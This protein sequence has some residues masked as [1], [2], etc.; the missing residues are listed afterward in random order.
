MADAVSAQ[1]WYAAHIKPLLFRKPCKPVHAFHPFGLELYQD[2]IDK[3]LLYL[4]LKKALEELREFLISEAKIAKRFV[5]GKNLHLLDAE[6]V[7]CMDSLARFARLK[8]FDECGIPGYSTFR[9]RNA[10]NRR[11]GT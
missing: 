3:N 9:I 11:F 4:C 2:A 7:K 10:L 5:D 1:T 6:G 8:R